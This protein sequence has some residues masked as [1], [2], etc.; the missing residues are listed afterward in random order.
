[1]AFSSCLLCVG[2]SQTNLIML[3]EIAEALE[4][5]KEEG[6]EVVESGKRMLHALFWE[7]FEDT[8]EEKLVYIPKIYDRTDDVE[9]CYQVSPRLG[10]NV[11][12][13]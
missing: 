3:R 8:L 5:W 12:K 1:M 10:W 13:L 4:N 6:A 2:K 7:G 11:V 9:V